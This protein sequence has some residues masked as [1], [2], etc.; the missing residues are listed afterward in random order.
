MENDLRAR[1][2]GAYERGGGKGIAGRDCKIG[3]VW[4]RYWRMV[5]RY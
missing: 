1:R 5:N 4:T 3:E 2:I